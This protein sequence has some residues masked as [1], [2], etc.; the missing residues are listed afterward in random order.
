MMNSEKEQS[1]RPN[2][3][4]AAAILACGVGVCTLGV[5]VLLTEA[6]SGLGKALNLI[7]SVGPLSGKVVV[8]ILVWLVSWGILH[9]MWGQSQVGFGKI[10]WVAFALIAVGFVLTFPPVFQLFE[11]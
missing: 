1:P 7:D 10:T 5:F 3:A 4:A 11:E 8:A 9:K 2:G 6:R